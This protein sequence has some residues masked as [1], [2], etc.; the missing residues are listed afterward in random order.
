MMASSVFPKKRV[1][2]IILITKNLP[3]NL[4]DYS[5]TAS[6]WPIEGFVLYFNEE[7]Y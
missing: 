2:R 4:S 6:E 7:E 1:F 3:Y 5:K